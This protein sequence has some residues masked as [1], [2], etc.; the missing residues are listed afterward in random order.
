[1]VGRVPPQSSGRLRPS[2][3]RAA[4]CRSARIHRRAQRGAG[5]PPALTVGGRWSIFSGFPTVPHQPRARRRTRHGRETRMNSRSRACGNPSCPSSSDLT[6]QGGSSQG[7]DTDRRGTSAGTWI[8]RLSPT[9]ESTR[10]TAWSP[11]AAPRDPASSRRVRG[12]NRAG[13][14]RCDRRNPLIR[15]DKLPG[16]ALPPTA[17]LAARLAVSLPAVSPLLTVS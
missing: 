8:T 17:E 11:T 1:M 13:A 9:I 2:R 7:P 3:A 6:T 4:R 14:P 5:V 16:T 15:R 12:R 10:F